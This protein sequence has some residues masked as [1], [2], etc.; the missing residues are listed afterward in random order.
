MN[1]DQKLCAVTNQ[2][3][4]NAMF[5]NM[6]DNAAAITCGFPGDPSD[7]EG[8]R[9]FKWVGQSW[10]PGTATMHLRAENNNYL[11]ISSFYPDPDT[12]RYRR[13]KALFA[14]MHGMMVDDIGTKVSK[15][16]ITLPLSAL[17]ET[18]PGN[19]QGWYFIKDSAA[20]RDF[21]TC[22][23]L[24]KEM[25]A[26]GLTADG[27][28]PGMNGVTRYGRLPVGVNG[29]DKYV[30]ALGAAFQCRTTQ[31]NPARR[32]RIEDIAKAYKLNLSA[33][34][35]SRAPHGAHPLPKGEATRRVDDFEQMLKALSKAGM[36]LSSRGE[37]HD[38]VCPW[39]DDHTDGKVGGSA[40]Y[41]PAAGNG[42]IG[43]FKCWHGHCEHRTV[44]DVYRFA[45][46]LRWAA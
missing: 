22:D 27:S 1:I 6:P 15:R 4:L 24:I 34:A 29:K 13:R 23:Q 3:F 7:D 21:A 8:T 14:Q 17:V 28:D 32:Y 30:K 25:I 11:A 12:R 5:R 37:W 38:I 40:L 46:A 44:G 35:K 31:W 39:V 9:K 10:W 26:S 19:F 43:G 20:A 2:Q 41:N 42:W 36:Y 33:P 18:S 45:H 16:K